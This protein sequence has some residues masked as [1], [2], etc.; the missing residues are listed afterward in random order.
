MGDKIHFVQRQ[1]AGEMGNFKGIGAGGYGQIYK[2][3]AE[4]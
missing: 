1:G 3:G 2:V 4:Y